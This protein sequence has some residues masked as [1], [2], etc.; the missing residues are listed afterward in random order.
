MSF[1]VSKFRSIAV[2]TIYYLCAQGQDAKRSF[3]ASLKSNKQA[4]F[5]LSDRHTG[6]L[7][8]LTCSSKELILKR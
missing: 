2:N 6:K 7:L 1:A 3:T 4:L 8:S 5:A